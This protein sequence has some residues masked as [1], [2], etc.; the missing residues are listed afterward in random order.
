MGVVVATRMRTFEGF[1]AISNFVILPLYFLS[2]GVFPIQ[3]LPSWM[4]VLVHLNP[5]TYGVDLMRA[6]RS[7]RA[8]RF[9]AGDGC[10]QVVG[11][12]QRCHGSDHFTSSCDCMCMM[13]ATHTSTAANGIGIGAR[14]GRANRRFQSNIHDLIPPVTN[15]SDLR[16]KITG[17]EKKL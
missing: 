14:T 12:W 16:A 10:D 3:R 13:I 1:G 2:G 5:V 6:A 4:A 17:T 7:R 8:W 15:Y 9:R 11:S